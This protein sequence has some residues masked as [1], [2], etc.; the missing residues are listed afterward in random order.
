MEAKMLISSTRTVRTGL[1]VGAVV[2]A[3]LAAPALRADNDNDFDADR[4]SSRRGDFDG[5]RARIRRGF[6]IVPKGVQLDLYG[7]NRALAG[8]GSYIVNAQGGCNDCHTHP[9]Y[10]PG[11]DPFQGQPEMI[12]AAQ[13]MA[14][15][16]QFGPLTAPNITPDHAGRPH[17]LTRRQ[18]IETMRT[19][20]NPHDP[21][22]Q[23]L[24]VMPWPVYGKM[25]DHD[26]SAMYE[27]LRS[28]P[29]L[30]DN[31]NPGP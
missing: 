5:D 29:S 10:A 11:G 19:G 28:L 8:L 22:G 17:G 21:A 3:T 9:N 16:R 20:H 15:G 24:Q 4:A 18:F 7:K 1:L 12:N 27:F 30:P 6:E 31:P 14:G 13:Y 25:T 26:L 23:V 2:M